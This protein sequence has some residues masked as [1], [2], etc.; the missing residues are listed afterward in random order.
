MDRNTLLHDLTE[1]ERLMVLGQAQ[2]A[3]QEARIAEIDCNS[4]E[5]QEAVEALAELKA[6]QDLYEQR[7]DLI[8]REI[9]APTPFRRSA[10][11]A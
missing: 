1:V 11:G 9:L 5:R 7:R 10:P 2:L 8:L 3:D 4:D 6:M